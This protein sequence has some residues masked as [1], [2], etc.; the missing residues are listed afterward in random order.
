MMHPLLP[1]TAG[2]PRMG[3][4]AV[5]EPRLKPGVPAFAD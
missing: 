1:S 4:P 2:T 5:F 3:V